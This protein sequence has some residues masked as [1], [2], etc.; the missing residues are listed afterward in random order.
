MWL[1]TRRHDTS[2]EL[3]RLINRSRINTSSEEI[4]GKFLAETMIQ[5][6][7]CHMHEDVQPLS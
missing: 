3:Y 4:W 1:D 2:G 6:K 5:S 7:I